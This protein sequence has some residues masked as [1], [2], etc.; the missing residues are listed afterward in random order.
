[1]RKLFIIP[2]LL[3]AGCAPVVNLQAAEDANNPLCAE[4]SVRVPDTLGEL[5]KRETNSQ[6]TAAWGEPTAVLMRCGL[7]GVEVSTL[8]CVTAGEV[9][10][11]VDDSEAPTYRFI[12]Y[13]R[14][15]AVEVIVDST[16]ASGVSAL[17]GLSQAVSQIPATKACSNIQG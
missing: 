14:F 17:E 7:E 6:A 3:L 15:P 10:W 4:V 5:E 11:L 9:D 13:A 8:P 16:L 2:V 1:M 12:S